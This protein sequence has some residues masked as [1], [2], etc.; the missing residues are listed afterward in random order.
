MHVDEIFRARVAK[1]C[2]RGELECM[3]CFFGKSRQR[4]T[5][6]VGVNLQVLTGG[7]WDREEEEEE[8]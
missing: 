7:S 8:N 1:L 2:E 6:E 5:E 4:N 3:T